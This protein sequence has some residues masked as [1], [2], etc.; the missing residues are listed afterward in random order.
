MNEYDKKYAARLMISLVVSYIVGIIV[1]GVFTHFFPENAIVQE[2]SGLV[3]PACLL[4][5]LLYIYK[6]Y[7]KNKNSGGSE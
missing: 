7:T 5:T 4:L 2:F 1:E 6:V 3:I